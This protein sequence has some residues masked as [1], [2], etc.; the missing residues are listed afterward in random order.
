MVFAQDHISKAHDLLLEW[1][2]SH[3]QL[4]LII[5]PLRTWLAS[6]K[7]CIVRG[8][9]LSNPSDPSSD[10][11]IEALLNSIQSVLSVVPAE[12]QFPISNQDNYLKDT[13][14]SLTR[15]GDLLRV[16]SKVALMN[17]LIGKLAGC[18]PEE[19]K[20]SISRLLPFLQRYTLL[21][22]EQL[23]C[24]AR[25]VNSLFK[26]QLT[27]CSA[28]L[29]IATNGFCK[30]P[31][32]EELGEGSTEDG[33][34]AGGV[35]LGEGG[36]DENVSKE[37]EDVSQVEGLKD[38]SGESI[39]REEGGGNDNDA[40]EIGDDFQGELENI[41]ESGSEGE[42]PTDEDEEG[43]EE[44]LGDLDVGD[45]NTVDEK[46]W[47]DETGPQDDG[48]QSKACKDHSSKPGATSEVVAKENEHSKDDHPSR[49]KPN[50]LE[51]EGEDSNELKD[52]VISRDEADENNGEDAG[53]N[54]AELKDSIQD[55]DTLDL[56][57]GLEM[58]EDSMQQEAGEEVDDDMLGDD[59]DITT[60]LPKCDNG[61]QPPEMSPH[62]ID[63]TTNGES[64]DDQRQEGDGTDTELADP[65]PEEDISM[66]PDLRSGPETS[67]EAGRDSP[68]SSNIREDPSESQ[69]GGAQGT[70]AV[71]MSEETK[72]DNV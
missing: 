68:L 17:S 1:E 66:Q 59:T 10:Q 34:G 5:L 8:K 36:G 14:A 49:E 39:R 25:W 64:L 24:L 58:D 2:K 22:R 63:D 71:G 16:D 72:S 38:E 23:T 27:A 18:P 43:L 62:P 51:T 15:I 26:L 31:D 29:N 67:N 41:P 35:G 53:D 56:P 20:R 30:P 7:L 11:V 61:T 9:Q 12:D 44:T 52:E 45:P 55:S 32:G 33:S 50:D 37:I 54:G 57:D 47:G 40:I 28:I 19:V 13:S 4:R 60:D 70:K 48:D 65:H 42:R 21:V 46:L 6:Q 3:P 69:S